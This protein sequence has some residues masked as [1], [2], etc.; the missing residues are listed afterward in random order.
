MTGNHSPEP[1]TRLLIGDVAERL[2]CSTAYVRKLV[3][4]GRLSTVVVGIRSP[5]HT[6]DQREVQDLAFR[7]AKRRQ[8]SS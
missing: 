7:R 1:H 5:V 6:F 2:G 8:R 4:H 3:E